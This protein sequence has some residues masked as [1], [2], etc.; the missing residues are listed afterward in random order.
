[1]TFAQTRVPQ[2][3][4][5]K[6]SLVGNVPFERI[7]NI[8]SLTSVRPPELPSVVRN[9]QEF[10]QFCTDLKN[11]DICAQ[12]LVKNKLLSSETIIER[13]QAL[14]Q[15]HEEEKKIFDE[16]TG[17]RVFVDSDN[18]ELTDYD[19]VNIY[20]TNPKDGDTDRDGI[21]DGDE[22][23]S[24]SNPRRKASMV[25]FDARASTTRSVAPSISILVAENNPLVSGTTDQELLVVKEVIAL[26]N[27][28]STSASGALSNPRTTHITFTGTAMPNS[29]VTLYIFSEPIVV[30]VKTN[31]IGEWSYT[32]D[33]ELPD[34]THHVMS[35][36]TDGDGRVLAKSSPLPFVKVAQ[37]V[38]LGNVDV[39]LPL[40]HKEPGFFSGFSL[41]TLVALM[42]GILGLSFLVIGVIVR[43]QGGG[44]DTM[45]I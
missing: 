5:V 19:E 43:R 33:K 32:L 9:P 44:S 41:Y 36:I 13:T 20:H 27:A 29:F 25:S 31:S 21:F 3:S 7:E 8:L 42:V 26:S 30:M 45:A 14:R 11:I 6:P 35:A 22:I 12:V 28:T 18:D 38:T 2:S 16:R 39:A 24:R 37:A 17:A 34:G 10:Q 1:V 15:N 23:S 4:P 40:A